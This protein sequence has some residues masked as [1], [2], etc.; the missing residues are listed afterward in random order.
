M[1]EFLNEIPNDKFSTELRNKLYRL[2]RKSEQIKNLF[3]LTSCELNDSSFKDL[4]KQENFRLPTLNNGNIEII[5]RI[6]DAKSI[7]KDIDK[8]NCIQ[9]AVKNYRKTYHQTNELKYLIRALELIRKVKSVFE[10]EL[11]Q[12]ELVIIEIFLKLDNSHLQLKLIE[13]TTF[14]IQE[15]SVKHLIDYSVNKLDKEYEENNYNNALNYIKM[16]SALKHYK[17]NETKIQTALCLE[18][19]ADFNIN[20][21]EPNTYYPRILEIYTKALRE[22]KGVSQNDELKIRLQNKVKIEQRLLSEMLSKIGLKTHTTPNVS[23][24]IEKLNINDFQSAFSTIIEFPIIETNMLKSRNEN[25][26]KTFSGQFFEDFV[27]VTN[28][29]TVSGVSDEEGYYLNQARDHF[30]TNTI[31][32]LREVKF[33]MDINHQLVSKELVAVMISKCNSSF[34]PNDRE[35]FFIEGIYQGF[36]NNYLLAS[37]ILI[38]QIENSLKYIIELNGRNTIKL[39][40]EIQNDNT[41]GSILNIE[42]N[43]K[44]LGGVCESDLLLELNNFLSDGNSVNFRNRL[45]HG[46][47]SPFET[48]YYGIYL[49]WLTLKMIKQTDKYFTIPK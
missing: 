42:G 35:H 24:V 18:K 45:C 33:I 3:E 1:T 43:N 21:K 30:R 20:Q 39:T 19:E 40:E 27:R 47:L 12:L 41:L 48:N 8:L 34:I 36:Q 4:L 14:F 15:N 25:R 7:Y 13:T 16:L 9:K 17:N 23:E 28:K 38:P 44:M 11:P 46:L 10:K 49:W 5:A 29:G 32:F 22:I 2:S 26:E 31:S 37:H 6:N